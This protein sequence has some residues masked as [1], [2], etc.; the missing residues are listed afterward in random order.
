MLARGLNR[1][2]LDGDPTA[3]AEIVALREA[4]RVQGNH[5]L[6]GALLVS[7]CEPCPMCWGAAQW[8]RVDAVWFASCRET[9][10]GAGFD[11]RRFHDELQLDPSARS[12]V[13]QLL[14]RPDATLPFVDWGARGDRV[15]Y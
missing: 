4:C 5:V 9:A 2:T 8:A 15:G 11:D 6:T 14:T 3:H 12:P 10:A 7:S 13:G 1:V